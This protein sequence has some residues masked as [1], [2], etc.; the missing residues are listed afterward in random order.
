MK[1]LLDS[2]T[3]DK[4]F[5]ISHEKEA[6]IYFSFLGAYMESLKNSKKNVIYMTENYIYA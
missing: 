4:L 3:T 1:Y 2:K 5:I 6:K